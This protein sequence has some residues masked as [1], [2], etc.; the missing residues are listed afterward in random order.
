MILQGVKYQDL[1]KDQQNCVDKATSE[2][3]E[4]SKFEVGK[5]KYGGR[6][7]GPL[8]SRKELRSTVSI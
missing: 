2:I 3:Y 4:R 8:L 7:N 1:T 6:H 5:P